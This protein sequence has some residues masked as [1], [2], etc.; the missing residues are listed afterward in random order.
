[1]TMREL[2]K[3]TYASA[4]YIDDDDDDDDEEEDDGG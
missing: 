1:M 2:I 3:A 4:Q